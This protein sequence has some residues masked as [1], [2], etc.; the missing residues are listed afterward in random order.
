MQIRHVNQFQLIQKWNYITDMQMW[1]DLW[2]IN[3]K[4]QRSFSVQ[5]HPRAKPRVYAA[6]AITDLYLFNCAKQMWID[7]DEEHCWYASFWAAKSVVKVKLIVE[8]RLEW[9]KVRV[10]DVIISEAFLGVILIKVIWNFLKLNLKYFFGNFWFLE[11]SFL[12]RF[13]RDLFVT[14]EIWLCKVNTVHWPS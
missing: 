2:E 6:N 8:I 5:C 10:G 3:L 7:W 13:L 9:G 4:S 14:N 11:K 12:K 1:S